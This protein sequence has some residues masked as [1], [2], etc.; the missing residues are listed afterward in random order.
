MITTI[1]FDL[2]GLLADTEP[3]QMQ[4]YR[5]ALL[6]YG[7]MLTDDEYAQHWIRAGLGID[8]FVADRRLSIAPALVRQQKVQRYQALLETSL[9]AMP[10]TLDLLERLH[11]RKRLAVASSSFRDNVEQVLHR[12]NFARYFDVVAA[13]EDVEHGKPAPDIFLYTARRLEVEPS[14]CVVVEDAEKGILA[15]KRAGMKSIAVP[16]RH[17]LDNDF[18]AASYVVNSLLE[19]ECLLKLL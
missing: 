7:V 6:T 9:H 19:V 4:A 15:A 10:G 17:T 18:S 14:E 5:Q 1:I 13:G 8:Q 2:D 12:L 11:R 3:L 16:N